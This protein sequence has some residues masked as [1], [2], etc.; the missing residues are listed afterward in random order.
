VYYGGRPEPVNPLVA[1]LGAVVGAV[2]G[3]VVGFFGFLLATFFPHMLHTALPGMTALW[4]LVLWI[5][6]LMLPVLWFRSVWTGGRGLGTKVFAVSGI[7][8]V[9]GLFAGELTGAVRVFPW[10]QRFYLTP[11]VDR[12]DPTPA[13]VRR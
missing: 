12:P 3:L 13:A 11:A 8:I 1:A 10:S 5:G 4:F 7:A 2:A 6:A 9:A